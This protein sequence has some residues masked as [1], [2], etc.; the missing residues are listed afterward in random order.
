MTGWLYKRAGAADGYVVNTIAGTVTPV[1]VAAGKAARPLNVGAYTYPTVITVTGQTAV[2]L[3]PY[4]YT[5]VLINLKTRHVL[6]PIPVGA[7][8][9]AVAITA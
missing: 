6:P 1:G 3:E 9:T 5:V 8:P 4:G 7:F 2:V